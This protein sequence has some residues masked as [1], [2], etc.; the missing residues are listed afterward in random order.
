MAAEDRNSL[1]SQRSQAPLYSRKPQYQ[2][3]FEGF[4]Q[5][6]TVPGRTAVGAL[7]LERIKSDVS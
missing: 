1:I 5:R 6:P 2:C 4:L 7:S 3:R